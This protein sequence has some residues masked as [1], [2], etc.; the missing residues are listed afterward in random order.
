MNSSF[1]ER[2]CPVLP[3]ALDYRAPGI[4]VG[5]AST[6][7]WTWALPKLEL[8]ALALEEADAAAEAR[9]VLAGLARPL[10]GDAESPGES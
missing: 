3:A 9:R 4:R 5:R 10:A 8:R 6:D 1:V 7:T 2:D